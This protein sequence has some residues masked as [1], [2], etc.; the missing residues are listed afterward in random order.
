MSDRKH[1]VLRGSLTEREFEKLGDLERDRLEY[2]MELERLM[3]EPDSAE[4]Q[5]KIALITSRRDRFDYERELERIV[6]SCLAA[7]KREI[8]VRITVHICALG[9]LL[10]LAALDGIPVF[11]AKNGLGADCH[12]SSRNTLSTLGGL[13]SCFWFRVKSNIEVMRRS[14][15]SGNASRKFRRVD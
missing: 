5:R 14:V 12:N 13:M 11:T 10:V 2:E 6:A 9:F 8:A 7:W 3:A 1:D 15:L 4:R